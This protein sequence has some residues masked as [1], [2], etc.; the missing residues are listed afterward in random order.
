MVL[1]SDGA[2]ID[3]FWGYTAPPASFQAKL[4]KILKGEDTFKVVSAAYT[5]N[6]GDAALAFKLAEKWGDRY[7]AASQAKSREFYK[8]VLS[9]D[10][11]GR[12]GG[13]M[14]E[15]TK[16]IIPYTVSAAYVLAVSAARSA[17]PD[18]API[19]AFIAKYP[20]SP[21]V[22]NAYTAMTNHYGSRAPKEEAAAF[23][24]E[25]AA[26][27]PED[28]A[29]LQAWL[30]RLMRDKEPLD[31]GLEIAEKIELLTQ[32]TPDSAI[33]QTLSD[34]YLAKGDQA[35]AAD[36][37]GRG[38]ADGEVQRLAASLIGYAAYWSARG[39]NLEHATAMAE[40]SV[41]LNPGSSYALRQTALLYIK[42][43]Q[44]AKAVALYGPEW[45]K[46]KMADPFT[47][48]TYA[49]FWA[50]QGKNLDSAVAAARMIVELKPKMYSMWGTLGE[51]LAKRKNTAEAAQAYQK[52]VELAPEQAKP[53]LKSALEKLQ[54][55]EKK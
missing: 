46:P 40:I 15:S 19:R 27:Y 34:F 45:I 25:Y 28:P 8:K 9:L 44:D 6:P 24:A 54:M 22:R 55:P 17:N 38:Y 52:A 36:V 13:T 23:F 3:W 10:P 2:E 21:L 1:G 12:A 42:A 33:R 35:K 16:A 37:F 51:V 20:R 49:S 18:M 50:R 43:G 26:R 14:D 53:A 41:R 48:A 31:K 7:D 11:E 30:S 32:R 4:E 39:E 29:V 5:Q 47:L